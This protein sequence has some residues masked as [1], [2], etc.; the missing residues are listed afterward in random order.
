MYSQG[1]AQM[2]DSDK[3][4][5]LDNVATTVRN[6]AKATLI[7]EMTAGVSG[8]E[9]VDELEKHFNS[10]LLNGEVFKILQTIRPDIGQ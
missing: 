1:Y 4:K 10:K 3:E 2:E 5:L 9:L 8:Q 7:A 6:L